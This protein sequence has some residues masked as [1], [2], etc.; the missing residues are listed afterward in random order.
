MYVFIYTVYTHDVCGMMVIY[1]YIHLCLLTCIIFRF[2]ITLL[3][4]IEFFTY[5]GF[6][7][8]YKNSVNLQFSRVEA[9]P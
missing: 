1:V 4:V 6:D 8:T 3:F 9:E 2:D 5:E 7:I